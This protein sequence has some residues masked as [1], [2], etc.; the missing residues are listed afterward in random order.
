MEKLG[1]IKTAKELW[2]ELI[3]RAG[4][5]SAKAGLM[6]P[7][8]EGLITSLREQLFPE[9]DEDFADLIDHSD[10]TAEALLRA[11]F[12]CLEP[13]ARMKQDILEL[14]T[15]AGAHGS[16]DKLQIRF[17]FDE[18]SSP[19]D[20]L[21][22]NFRSQM[23]VFAEALAPSLPHVEYKN[24]WALAK[25]GFEDTSPFVSKRAEATRPS[26]VLAWIKNYNRGA[27][28]QPLAKGWETGDDE[29]DARLKRV[30]T[31]MNTLL[32]RFSVYGNNHQ[33]LQAA[34]GKHKEVQNETGFSVQDLWIIESDYWPEAVARWLCQV[35]AAIAESDEDRL[36]KICNRVDEV[37]PESGDFVE[38]SVRTLEDILDLPIWKHRH[39]VYAVWLGAQM[40]HA[41][42]SAGWNFRF[43]LNNG[44]LEFAFRGVH[45]A[46]LLRGENEPELFWWTE[47]RTL[48]SDLPNNR[49]KNGI[50]PDYRIRRAP[51]SDRD[52][53]ILVVEAKQH[54]RSN[55]KEFR[56]AIEDYSY[57][58]PNAGVLLANYGPCSPNLLPAITEAARKKSAAYG[59]MNPSEPEIIDGFR[60]DLGQVVDR[61]L[62][63]EVSAVF[64]RNLKITLTWGEEPADLDL[65]VFNHDGRHVYYADR[66]D[67]DVELGDDIQS[68]YGS[69]TATLTGEG[70]YTI[71][72]HQYSEDGTFETSNAAVEIALGH[73]HMRS[74]ER[75]TVPKGIGHWW[76][77][78]TIDLSKYQIV[79]LTKRSSDPPTAFD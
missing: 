63:G 47:L 60:N 52:T 67:K 78:A 77:V 17:H 6:G 19:L 49:R 57:A 20:M 43:H 75:L 10:L 13:F 12:S 33:E 32:G 61:A 31:L 18:D 70:C 62:E 3:Q 72:V 34:A 71:A 51:L 58:C 21:L 16:A 74:I 30:V 41:L 14:L 46:T 1:T 39:E 2:P 42:R 9:S 44:R 37:L 65:H 73:L 45:L 38:S 53:D 36:L 28:F 7:Y 48:H 79:P 76:H 8:D 50:Q 15:D 66:D 4:L 27:S 56:E 55:N 11:F 40:Y 64:E 25:A 24:L 69:E 26:A 23:E 22:S 68:G 5:T 59:G 54:L 29:L 35:H